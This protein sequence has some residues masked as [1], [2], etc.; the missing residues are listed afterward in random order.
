MAQIKWTKKAQRLYFE[1][2]LY[3]YKEFG[4]ATA[5]RWHDNRKRIE[6]QLELYPESYSFESIL[7][8]RRLQYRSCHFMRRFKI[9]YFYARTSNTVHIVDIWDTRMSP[10][11]LERRV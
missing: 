8:E 5:K 9:V 3:A 1:R 7:R 2:V 10:E 4:R 6:R 11:T